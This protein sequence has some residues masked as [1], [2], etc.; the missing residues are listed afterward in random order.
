MPAQSRSSTLRAGAAHQAHRAYS[1]HE[2][3]LPG[4]RGI[5]SAPSAGDIAPPLRSRC[6]FLGRH[7][8]RDR[9]PI[10]RPK[11]LQSLPSRQ[12]V[13]GRA[14]LVN[15]CS[16]GFEQRSDR[17][18]ADPHDLLARSPDRSRATHPVASRRWP[19]RAFWRPPAA[20]STGCP[21]NDEAQ[22]KRERM[23]VADREGSSGGMKEIKQTTPENAPNPGAPV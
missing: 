10:E 14:R 11:G 23:R 15:Q 16:L 20:G 22:R 7:G 3:G 12:H 4:R 8:G 18:R 13:N 1:S 6:Q 5:G 21:R 9:T 19:A 2:T 17:L